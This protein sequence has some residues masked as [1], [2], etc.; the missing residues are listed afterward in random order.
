MTKSYCT[1]QI[2]PGTPESPPEYCPYEAVEGADLCDYH[3][4]EPV[5]VDAARKAAA[6]DKDA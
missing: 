1:K 3:G 5:D 4:G 2:H 6:E